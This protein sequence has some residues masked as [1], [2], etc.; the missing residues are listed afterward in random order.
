MTPV[1][2]SACCAEGDFVIKISNEGALMETSAANGRNSP[3][4][5]TQ[6]KTG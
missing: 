1:P 4:G 6:D 5:V 2:F 3:T